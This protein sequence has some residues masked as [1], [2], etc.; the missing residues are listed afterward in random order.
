MIVIDLI[1]QRRHFCMNLVAPYNPNPNWP[2]GYY[3]VLEEAGIPENHQRF[4]AH[5]VRQ[6]FSHNPGKRR[7]ELRLKEINGFLDQLA[8]QGIETWQLKQAHNA[9]EL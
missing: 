2:Q 4:Y 8:Q 5:W 6:F 3:Q 7:R 9:L 1:H